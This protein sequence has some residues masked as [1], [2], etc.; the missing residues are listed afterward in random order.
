MT[1]CSYEGHQGVLYES[2]GEVKFYGVFFEDILKAK[3]LLDK[4]DT[5]YGYE[6]FEFRGKKGFVHEDGYVVVQLKHEAQWFSSI[7]GAKQWIKASTPMY[8]NNVVSR[9]KA[10]SGGRLA[11]AWF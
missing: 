8:N 11:S 5:G 7:K 2:T 1:P 6:P 10:R 4:I 9:Q 3:E